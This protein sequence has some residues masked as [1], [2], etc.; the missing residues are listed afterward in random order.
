MVNAVVSKVGT[1]GLLRTWSTPCR[2]RILSPICHLFFNLCSIRSAVLL[3]TT[4]STWGETQTGGQ[5][6]C[7]GGLRRS[8]LLSGLGIRERSAKGQGE[9]AMKVALDQRTTRA[10]AGPK[11]WTT[12]TTGQMTTS[13][14]CGASFGLNAAKTNLKK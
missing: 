2:T 1:R 13:Y 7:E 8:L 5:G 9:M 4:P 11:R 6:G 14:F 10:F 3:T 12:S